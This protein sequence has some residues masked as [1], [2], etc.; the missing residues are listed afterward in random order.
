MKDFKEVACRKIIKI[1]NEY[2]IFF[3]VDC[4]Y[5]YYVFFFYNDDGYKRQ[6]NKKHMEQCPDDNILCCREKIKML[7]SNNS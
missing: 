7:K 6:N 4:L 3:S 5:L 2:F 1:Q